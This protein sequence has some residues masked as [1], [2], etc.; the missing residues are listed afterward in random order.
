MLRMRVFDSLLTNFVGVGTCYY[1]HGQ[2]SPTPIALTPNQSKAA[3]IRVTN[4]INIVTPP[5][6]YLE[7]ACLS[8]YC[9]LLSKKG[10]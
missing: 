3:S 9:M 2:G 1:S 4:A 6:Y 5:I 7:W 8:I 10:F